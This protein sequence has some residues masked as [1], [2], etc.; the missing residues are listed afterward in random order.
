MSHD[1]FIT[2]VNKDKPWA[3]TMVSGLENRGICCWIAPRDI[4]P[5]TSWVQAIIDAIDSSKVMVVIFS[6]NSNQSSQVVREVERALTKNIILIPFRIENI[7]PTGALAH[8]LATEHWVDA[9]TP[10]MEEHIYMLGNTIQLLLTKG[11]QEDVEERTRPPQDYSTDFENARMRMP[12]TYVEERTS[13]P[14]VDPVPGLHSQQGLTDD[15]KTVLQAF[16]KAL[17]R[18]QHTLSEHPDILWQQMHNRLQWEGDEVKPLIQQEISRRTSPKTSPWLWLKSPQHESQNLYR[19]INCQSEV[20]KCLFSPDGKYI[21]A[22][23]NWATELFDSA[24]GTLI[25][26]IEGY[27]PAISP[28]GCWVATFLEDHGICIW[29]VTTGRQTHNLDS[30]KEGYKAIAFSP[31]GSRIAAARVDSV[32]VWDFKAE[33]V[34]RNF[35]KNSGPIAFSPTKPWIVTCTS[36]RIKIWNY[37]TGHLIKEW[38]DEHSFQVTDCGFSPDGILLVTSGYDEIVRIWTA[39]TGKKLHTLDDHRDRVFACTFSPDGNSI[40]TACDDKKVR[41]YRFEDLRFPSELVGHTHFAVCCAFSPDGR[42]IASGSDDKTLR[43]W[44]TQGS[45][46]VR[47]QE[48]HLNRARS[49]RFSPNGTTIASSGDDC[50]VRLWDTETGKAIK[51][52]DAHAELEVEDCAFSPDG[53]VHCFCRLGRNLKGL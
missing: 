43:I 32:E 15:Q 49:C 10:P 52:I 9:L 39:E 16:L 37:E 51:T 34:I 38:W 6:G 42:W 44:D 12:Y 14:R 2:Y 21:V 23:V 7:N 26:N 33:N 53:P 45:Y 31:D 27:F 24:T 40:V 36:N 17:R 25:R 11:E 48:S 28:D 29:E 4:T 30:N 47:S 13:R 5:G 50:S 18:E 1:V 20:Q 46:G 3:D 22:Q 41:L 35:E 19:T 8:S